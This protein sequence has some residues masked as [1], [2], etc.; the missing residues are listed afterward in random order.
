M[1]PEQ[2]PSTHGLATVIVHPECRFEV[3]QKADE[4]G[5]TEGI[6][7]AVRQSPPGVWPR[8]PWNCAGTARAYAYVP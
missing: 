5:S 3:A 1:R 6:L 4:I 7:K 8:Q 2:P